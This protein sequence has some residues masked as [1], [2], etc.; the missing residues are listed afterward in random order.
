M[1]AVASCESLINAGFTTVRDA[2]GLGVYLKCVLE[3]GT[4]KHEPR[5]RSAN[6]VLL[7]EKGRK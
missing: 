1:R 3:E 4:I 6:K 2:G 5:I 7:T